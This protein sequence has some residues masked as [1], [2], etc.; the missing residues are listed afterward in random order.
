MDRKDQEHPAAPQLKQ[1]MITFVAVIQCILF[2]AHWF[3]Y[4]TWSYFHPEMS[5]V[6]SRWAALVLT[7]L[8]LS[9]V[10]AT[11][12]TH[13][14]LNPI[15]KL[16]YRLAAIWMGF[17]NFFFWG[18]FACWALYIT[19][20]A[21]GFHPVRTT[22]ANTVF[23]IAVVISLYGLVNARWIRI[24][25][26]SIK[27]PNL[28]ESWRG[29]VGALITDIH[30]GPINGL[31]FL[32]RVVAILKRLRPDVVF[33]TGD[34]FDGGMVDPNVLSA[35]K[36]FSA[37]FGSYFVTGNHEEFTD[38]TKYLNAV[39]NSGIRVLNNERV[40]VEGLQIVGVHDRETADAERLRSILEKVSLTRDEASILLAH[41]PHRLEVVE[42][43]GISL[44]VSGH[45][46]GGQIFPFTWL[47]ERVFGKHT[48]G[49]SKFGDLNVYTSSGTGTWGPPM[50][51]GTQ[52]E[53]LLI[54]FE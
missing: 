38:R 14:Y 45:T 17:F 9:F 19:C 29:R 35:W 2:I 34:L 47:T 18:S 20:R 26:L 21:F 42:Q 41:I 12:L 6:E 49:L 11:L 8:S 33:I 7:L 52:P 48:Y 13:R 3:V 16:L 37:K 10:I 28:P 40:V 53:I 27:L 44:Q 1:R 31:R 50:R 46:H 51:V 25:R 24:R 5:A 4:A 22:L 36:G 23:S 43:A 15:V 30:L 54:E 32:Q 39:N